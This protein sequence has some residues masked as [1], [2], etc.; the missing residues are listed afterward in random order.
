MGVVCEIEIPFT[1]VEELVFYGYAP[2]FTNNTGIE[3]CTRKIEPFNLWRKV[4]HVWLATG[5]KGTKCAHA[6]LP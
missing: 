2:R 3:Y 5:E 1:F 6:V 4:N